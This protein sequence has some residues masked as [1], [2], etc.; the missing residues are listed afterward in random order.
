MTFM[1]QRDIAKYRSEFVR[2]E[3]SR[4]YGNGQN[5]QEFNG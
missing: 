3:W 5:I 1:K 4:K 2:I